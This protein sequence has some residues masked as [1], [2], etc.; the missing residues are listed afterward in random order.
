MPVEVLVNPKTRVNS[1]SVACE[2]GIFNQEGIKSWD[3]CRSFGQIAR[4][5]LHISKAP[6]LFAN[7]IQKIKK[8]S[9]V[10]E[11]ILCK[12]KTILLMIYREDLTQQK[13]FQA[14][15][16]LLYLHSYGKER[17]CHM[18]HKWVAN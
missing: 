17:N 1:S 5:C 3:G 16:S 7:Q 9:D 11:W 2:N 4:W 13:R 12:A 6:V 18:S 15:D 10:N 14:V 8:D